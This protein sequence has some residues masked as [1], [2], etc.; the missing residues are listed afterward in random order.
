MSAKSINHFFNDQVRTVAE[1]QIEKSNSMLEGNLIN[2][3]KC[4]S[5]SAVVFTK[6]KDRDPNLCKVLNDL[7]NPL[8]SESFKVFANDS[9]S[10][11][12]SICSEKF[13]LRAILQLYESFGKMNNIIIG[14]KTIMSFI[15]NCSFSIKQALLLKM[16]ESAGSTSLISSTFVNS[17]LQGERSMASETKTMEHKLWPLRSG[18][19][20]TLF[21]ES[22]PLKRS[23]Q[24]VFAGSDRSASDKPLSFRDYVIE[25][26]SA[27][28]GR[29]RRRKNK[30]ASQKRRD[31]SSSLANNL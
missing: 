22:G 13:V 11:T 2:S 4:Y 3:G 26:K 14:I 17:V 10:L 24:E 15:S 23:F 7:F 16:K 18:V 1:A 8:G 25:C 29:E 19:D 27:H 28:R 12:I 6:L 20:W 21:L 31:F 30:S 5:L 9:F